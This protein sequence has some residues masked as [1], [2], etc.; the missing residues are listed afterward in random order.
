LVD[1]CSPDNCPAICDEYAQKDQRI[2]VI[3]NRQN[4]GSS[5]SRQ[6]GLA[7]AKGDYTLFV[8]SDDWIECNMLEEMYRKIT[9]DNLDIVF[10]G[11]CE[12]QSNKIVRNQSSNNIDKITIIKHFLDYKII[13]SIVICIVNRRLW[14]NIVFPEASFAEDIFIVSQLLY[15]SNR[16]DYIDKPFY[17]YCFN[18]ASLCRDEKYSQRTAEYFNSIVAIT[19][20]L[21]NKYGD[22]SIFDPELSNRINKAKL[23]IIL[24]KQTR[25]PY[26]LFDLYPHSNQLVFN[27]NSSLPFYHK[28]L[29]FLATKKILFPLRLLDL[30]YTLRK[31]VNGK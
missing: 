15:Y 30:Y 16:I 9:N 2:T 24:D 7:Q 8:D 18:P 5:L 4:Q 22:I 27:K 29:L 31:M 12:E 23:A 14:E 3:H 26:L 1:D 13:S 20:F 19:D 10:C 17:R 11:Y 21:L 28:A 6:T 25:D